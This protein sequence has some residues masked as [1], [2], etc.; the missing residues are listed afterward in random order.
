MTLLADIGENETKG[1]E[2]CD[3]YECQRICDLLEAVPKL[4]MTGALYV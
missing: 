1:S 2:D 3:S 4:I